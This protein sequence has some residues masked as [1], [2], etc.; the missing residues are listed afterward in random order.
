MVSVRVGSVQKSST[1]PVRVTQRGY[2]LA[3]RD[4]SGFG[5]QRHLVC[6]HFLR[7]YEHF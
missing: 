6:D 7:S 2:R 5:S 3:L 4:L 1:S